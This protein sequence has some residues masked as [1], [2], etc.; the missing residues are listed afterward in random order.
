MM[1]PAASAKIIAG[2]AALIEFRDNLLEVNGQYRRDISN[3]FLA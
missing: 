2:I 1:L 3:Y